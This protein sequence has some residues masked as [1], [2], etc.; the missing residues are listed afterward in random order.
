MSTGLAGYLR[1]HGWALDVLDDGWT[2]LRSSDGESSGYFPGWG[3]DSANDF[4]IDLIALHEERDHSS[5][6][7]DAL[8]LPAAQ[9]A[10]QGPAVRMAVERTLEAYAESRRAAGAAGMADGVEAAI[11]LL[12]SVS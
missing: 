6:M 3:T 12:R 11:A 9:W 10:S 4:V 5:V 2:T 7:A 1:A 8:S